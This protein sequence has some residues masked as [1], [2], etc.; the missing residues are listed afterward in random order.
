M[1]DPKPF[2]LAGIVGWP[3]AHSRSPTLH[4]YWL[5]HYGIPGRYVPLPVRPENLGAALPGLAALG[6]RGCN[7]TTPHKQAVMPLIHHVDPLAQRIGAVNTIVV[8]AD[9]TL[10]GFNNDG[11]GFVQ[12]LRDAR[13]TGIPTAD[14]SPSSA[15]A[16]RRAP[17]SPRSRRRARARSASST[18]R[19]RRRRRSRTTSARR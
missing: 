2:G 8:E 13:P 3:V 1:S 11:N 9:G 6:F 19:S 10:R 7:V 12:S 17:S 15:R 4:N 5:E 14:R 18:A 16:A